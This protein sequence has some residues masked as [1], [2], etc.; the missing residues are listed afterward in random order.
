MNLALI[1]ALKL[2]TLESLDKQLS[3]AFVLGID[4]GDV[5]CVIRPTANPISDCIYVVFFADFVIARHPSMPVY[6]YR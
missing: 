5:V 6:R 3:P 2:F 1:S 4:L